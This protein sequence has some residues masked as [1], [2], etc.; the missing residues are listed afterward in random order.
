M[1][2]EV[3]ADGKDLKMSS[4]TLHASTFGSTNS[5]HTISEEINL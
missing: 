4:F 1:S 3:E 2:K 5:I